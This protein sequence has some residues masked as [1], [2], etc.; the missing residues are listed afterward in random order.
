MEGARDLERGGAKVTELGFEPCL[1][2]S[3]IT[4]FCLGVALGFL[5]NP[6]FL[7]KKMPS[8]FKYFLNLG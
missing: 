3:Q 2:D 1:P 6:Q 5:S 7:E 4:V 8:D